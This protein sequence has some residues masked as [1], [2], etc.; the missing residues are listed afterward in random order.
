MKSTERSM[1]HQRSTN[2]NEN[3][4]Q[5]G[6][7]YGAHTYLAAPAHQNPCNYW[8]RAKKSGMNPAAAAGNFAG[9]LESFGEI[10]AKLLRSVVLDSNDDAWQ[11]CSEE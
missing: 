10:P 8:F 5:S 4:Y 9:T 2:R 11:L 1:E 3:L 7:V 6:R